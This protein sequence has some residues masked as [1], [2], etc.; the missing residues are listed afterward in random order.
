MTVAGI[1][2]R[3]TIRYCAPGFQVMV[4]GVASYVA[5]VA[6][7]SAGYYGFKGVRQLSRKVMGWPTPEIIP[8]APMPPP[9]AAKRRLMADRGRAGLR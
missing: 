4:G 7:A 6:V 5:G 8:P 1:A 9:P 3:S 2:A